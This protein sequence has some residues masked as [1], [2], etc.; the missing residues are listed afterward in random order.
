MVTPFI[1]QYLNRGWGCM[2]K[3]DFEVYI[4]NQIITDPNYAGKNDYELSTELAIPQAKVKRLR[5]ESNLKY[6]RNNAEVYNQQFRE[7]LMNAKP[8]AVNNGK[9]VKFCMEDKGLYLYIDNIL[10][11]DGRFG[12]RSFNSELMVISTEDLAYLLETTLL[13]PTEK[14]DIL[15]QFRKASN[16][17]SI[18]ISYALLE[19]AKAF[20]EGA[21]KGLTRGWK[22]EL[23]DFATKN[24]ST[25]IQ[26]ITEKNK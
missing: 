7:V 2:N 5:Y 23:W 6:G 20:A 22:V 18:T 26:W 12:D 11:K 13:S 16:D 15:T 8:Q 17:N 14:E 19:I 24:I 1:Q 4:F 9:A 10:K 3:N 21:G 25:L